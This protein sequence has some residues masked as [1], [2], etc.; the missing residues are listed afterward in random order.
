MM[1]TIRVKSIGNK[2]SE[3]HCYV[4]PGLLPID[5]TH[6]PQDHSSGSNIITILVPMNESKVHG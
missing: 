3:K 2:Q 1:P 5:F 6:I 4:F